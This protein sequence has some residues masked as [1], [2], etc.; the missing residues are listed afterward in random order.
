[1]VLSLG[2]CPGVVFD[3]NITRQSKEPRKEHEKG[4]NIVNFWPGWPESE[5]LS[6]SVGLGGPK[7][8]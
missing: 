5:V 7:V 1:M 3:E 6:P 4:I 2:F 8:Q